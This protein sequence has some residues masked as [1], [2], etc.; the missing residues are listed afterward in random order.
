MENQ[1]IRIR[2][3]AYD[4]RAHRP[5]RPGDRGDRQAH[6]R[7]VAGPIPLPTRIEKFSVNRSVHVNK[8]SAEQFEIRTH[9][10][11]LDIV[12]PDRPHRGRAQEAQPARRRRHHHP[13]LRSAI[14]GLSNFTIFKSQILPAMSLGLLGKKLGMTRLFDEQAGTMIPVTVIDVS[15]QHHPPDARLAETDG[16]TAVQVGY[17]DQK[18]QRVNKPALG[19]FKKA[20]SDAQALHPEFRFDDGAAA[21]EAAA[22]RRRH[23]SRRPVG[24]RDRHHQGQGFPGRRASATASAAS[25]RPTAP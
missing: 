5:L 8:K 12:D 21:P 4:H 10:R 18:E 9:K 1:K 17:D 13:H 19:H 24:R 14:P 6:R 23:S 22:S 20:G 2:L 15:R 16:Y 25:S 3:R 7:P 11:L